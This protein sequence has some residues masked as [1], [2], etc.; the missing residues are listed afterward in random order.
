[1]W[2][3]RYYAENLNWI[4]RKI[5]TKNPYRADEQR[6]LNKVVAFH[7]TMI[8]HNM[9]ATLDTESKAHKQALIH[10]NFLHEPEGEYHYANIAHAI[11]M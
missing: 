1:M 5:T 9:D 4:N 6:E 11:N 10:F 3:M 7:L 2:L 8:E